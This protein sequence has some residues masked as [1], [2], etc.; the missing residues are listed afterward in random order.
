MEGDLEAGRGRSTKRD[1]GKN[2]HGEGHLF[3]VRAIES[4][5]YGGVA[6]SRPTSVL[7]SAH[8]PQESQSSTLIGGRMSPKLVHIS[9]NASVTS[10]PLSARV[11]SPL[12]QTV[13]A[14]GTSRSQTPVPV[15]TP[16]RSRLRAW[17]IENTQPRPST[18]HSDIGIA[19]TRAP[20]P[21]SPVSTRHQLI[22]SNDG[23]PQLELAMND[24]RVSFRS[25][26]PAPDAKRESLKD[27]ASRRS[28][29]SFSRP[30][31]MKRRSRSLGDLSLPQSPPPIY[32]R[33]QSSTAGTKHDASSIRATIGP[34]SVKDGQASEPGIYFPSNV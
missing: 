9:P 13:I 17:E 14:H 15:A 25:I 34:R 1:L 6:Q 12:R 30:I 27:T 18:A 33:K 24:F 31:S 26:F 22:A 2:L 7:E 32:D 19:S 4:G 28:A 16:G 23:P 5:F 20:S 21:T 11:S 3:G 10:L 29:L 8:S